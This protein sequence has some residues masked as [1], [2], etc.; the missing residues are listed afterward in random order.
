MGKLGR[1]TTEELRR[2]DEQSTENMLIFYADEMLLI[3]GGAIASKL[4]TRPLVNR[5]VES[6]ILE[7]GHNNKGWRIMLS[8]KGR[9]FYGL[10]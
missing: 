1:F 3:D 2:F 9:D 4:L 10:P 7:L 6:G 8:R 5:F